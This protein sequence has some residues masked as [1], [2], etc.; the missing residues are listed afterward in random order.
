CVVA[1]YAGAGVVPGQALRP[2][3]RS[4]SGGMSI[5]DA[6]RYYYPGWD[7]PDEDDGWVK[8]LCPFHGES[9]PSAVV[10]VEDDGFKCFAC[11]AKGDTLNI[12]KYMEGGTR[13]DAK[14]LADERAIGHSEGLGK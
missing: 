2:R 7:P 8:V 3:G 10:S 13:A 12:I 1:G 11:D 4:I 6:I 5:V 9:R 14:R